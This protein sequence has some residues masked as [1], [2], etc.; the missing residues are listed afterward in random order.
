MQ[1]AF[2]FSLRVLRNGSLKELK[3]KIAGP[4]MPDP[5]D[6]TKKIPADQTLI[7]S[8]K[9]FVH[10]EIALLPAKFNT[11]LVVVTGELDRELG[12]SRAD[13]TVIGEITHE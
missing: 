13:I 1:S 6:K 4:E 12:R 7:E 9:T 8:V 11:A 2:S 10:G 5:K 3:S